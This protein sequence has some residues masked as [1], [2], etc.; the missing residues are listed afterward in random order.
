MTF[1]LLNILLSLAWIILTAQF[2]MFN[3]I[4]GYLFGFAVLWITQYRKEAVPAYFRKIPQVASFLVYFLWEVIMSNLRVTRDVISLR[5]RF[6][7]GIVGIKLDAATAAEI[8]LLA[9]LISLTPGTLSL[10]VSGDRK[11][12]YIHA[13]YIREAELFKRRIKEDMERRVMEVLR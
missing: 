9:N 10:D 8:S 5:P 2:S 11:V 12:L 6:R 7:P 1:F 13:M 4:I 3:L